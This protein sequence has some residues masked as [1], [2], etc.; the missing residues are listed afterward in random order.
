MAIQFLDCKKF[1]SNVQ[2]LKRQAV[3]EVEQSAGFLSFSTNFTC[4][5]IYR[6]T[7]DEITEITKCSSY[8]LFFM[9]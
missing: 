9:M 3:Q 5:Y 7:H 8:M 6:N 2:Q 1:L 4:S